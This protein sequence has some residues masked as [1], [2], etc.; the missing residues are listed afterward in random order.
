M[1]KII[2]ISLGFNIVGNIL[3]H[4]STQLYKDGCVV[5]QLLC[6]FISSSVT[7]T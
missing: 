5:I 2:R 3:D 6:F 1:M 4:V 7:E